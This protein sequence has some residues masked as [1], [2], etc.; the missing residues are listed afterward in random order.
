MKTAGQGGPCGYDANKKIKGRKRHLL[1]DTLGWLLGLQISAADVQ[2]RD[3]AKPLMREAA[4]Q[5]GR[6]A[7]TWADAGYAGKFAAWVKALRPR[8]KL[9]IEIVRGISGQKGFLVQ[10]RRWV[11]ERSFAWLTRCK[12]LV[13]D[14]ERLLSHSAAFIHLAFS[15]LMLRFLTR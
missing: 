13:K 12:R 4:V 15:G 8:G 5:F 14:Y 1:T 10:P 11:I 6:L 7:K 3:G 9:H 2:D